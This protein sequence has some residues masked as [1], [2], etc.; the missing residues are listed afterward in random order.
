MTTLR[1]LALLGLLLGIVGCSREGDPHGTC[2]LVGGPATD[3]ATFGGIEYQV[4]GGFSGHGDGTA[5]HIQ[6]DGTITVQ[7]PQ[8]GTGQGQLDPATL[9]SLV[10]TARSAQFPTL[11]AIYR[12]SGCT[13]DF[14]DQVSVQFDGSALTVLASQEGDPPDRLQAMID[15]LR[16]VA[17]HPPQ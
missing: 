1:H 12:C 13:D 2:D 15:A 10:G 11:C 8:R 4:V 14:V 5:L 3:R 7:T 9:A 17:Q 16:Q 6:P